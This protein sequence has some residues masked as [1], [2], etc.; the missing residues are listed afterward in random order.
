[1]EIMI[2]K[3][4]VCWILLVKVRIWFSGFILFDIVLRKF[5]EFDERMEILI[6][7]LIV[8]E[9][10]CKVFIIVVLCG[11]SLGGSWF[12]LFVWVG[13]IIIEM[14]IIS[15]MCRVMINFVDV[16]SVMVEKLYMVLVIIIRLGIIN[17]L[18][19]K[20]LNNFFIIGERILLIIFLGRSIRLVVK[21][22]K[23]NDVCKYK[24][25][26]IIVDNSIIM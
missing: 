9:I 16:F 11:Y 21:V 7:V 1:M 4:N 25:K 13:I 2:V 20:W 23:V 3:I 24:G 12:N 5:F 26:I 18:G 8:S 22:D 19:L 15:V 17:Y 14:V 6:V 10:C